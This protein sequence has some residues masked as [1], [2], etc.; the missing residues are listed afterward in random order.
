M[1]YIY[2]M[3]II[4]YTIIMCSLHIYERIISIFY[5]NCEKLSV[6]KDKV[7]STMDQQPVSEKGQR[8]N[9]LGFAGSK[10]S[11]ITPQRSYGSTME[12]TFP[13]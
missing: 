9:M 10:V 1:I 4:Y 11:I 3:Y 8:V 7:M 2:I 13:V 12:V 5:G 6:S